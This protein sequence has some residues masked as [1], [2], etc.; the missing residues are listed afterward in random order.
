MSKQAAPDD[1]CGR[2]EQCLPDYW[3]DELNSVDRIWLEKHLETCSQCAELANFWQELAQQPEPKPDPRQRRRF[4][5]MLAAYLADGS[6]RRVSEA[7][8]RWLRPLPASLALAFVLAGFGGGWWL[9]G[10][11]GIVLRDQ[12]EEIA[13]LREE[14]HATD[15]LVVLSMLQQQKANDRLEGVS[16]SKRINQPDPQIVKALLHLLQYDSSPNV[17]LAALDALQRVGN[18]GGAVQAISSGLIEAFSCQKSPLVQVAVVDSLLELRPP[19][20]RNLLQEVSTNPEYS[21]EVRQRA[22]WGLSHWN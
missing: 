15:E 4:D 22:A 8:V 1:P 13:A 2:A 10:I 14:V 7:W 17:R 6:R 5:A 20:A 21:P 3:Q 16:Y 19:T 12:A 18:A 11:T 9:R